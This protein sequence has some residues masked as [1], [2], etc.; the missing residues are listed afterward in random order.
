[1]LACRCLLV[2]WLASS[3]AVR[4]RG[5]VRG[6]QRVREAQIN[7]AHR[8]AGLKTPDPSQHAAIAAQRL[9]AGAASMLGRGATPA[10]VLGGWSGFTPAAASGGALGGRAGATPGLMRTPAMTPLHGDTAAGSISPGKAVLQL[11]RVYVWMPAKP[12]AFLCRRRCRCSAQNLE[13]HV[14]CACPS[15][16]CRLCCCGCLG[17]CPARWR[18]RCAEWRGARTRHAA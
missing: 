15:Y 9:Q 1:M 3:L 14:L 6:M 17:Q 10:S 12:D 4:G 13:T 2:D 7:I 8:R 11:I 16:V 18:R 5:R